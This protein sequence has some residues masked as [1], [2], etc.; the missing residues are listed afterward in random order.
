MIIFFF[1]SSGYP[2]AKRGPIAMACSRRVVP[3]TN[4]FYENCGK[5]DCMNSKSECSENVRK[6]SENI[7]FQGLLFRGLLRGF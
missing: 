3:F 6:R 2:R 1:A 5:E 7:W 4:N